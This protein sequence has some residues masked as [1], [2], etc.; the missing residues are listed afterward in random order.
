MRNI[1]G[2][3]QQIVV[4][5]RKKNSR[6]VR[7]WWDEGEM[8]CRWSLVASLFLYIRQHF[9]WQVIS[10]IFNAIKLMMQGHLVW[11]VFVGFLLLMFLAASWE[12]FIL[13]F[14]RWAHF[15][16]LKKFSELNWQRHWITM[17][18]QLLDLS[19]NISTASSANDKFPLA[20]N[21]K[22][23]LKDP[24]KMS[25]IFMPSSAIPSPKFLLSFFFWQRAKKKF[26][27]NW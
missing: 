3:F 5:V 13:F 1:P 15:W 24:F 10:D 26:L 9:M 19:R 20:Q 25:A 11:M 2:K 12:L 17:K 7:C 27:L 18:R 21:L 8:R 4:P 6:T 14:N 22:E 16:C 23:K